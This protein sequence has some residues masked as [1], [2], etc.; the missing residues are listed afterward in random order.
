M[1]LTD[2]L[3]GLFLKHGVIG[4]MKNF[5]TIIPLGDGQQITIMAESVQI[6]VDKG[7]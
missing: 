6:K 3:V 7:E 1:K 2:T 5:Q 4:E